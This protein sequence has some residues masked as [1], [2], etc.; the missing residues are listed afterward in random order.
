MRWIKE[1][2][3]A[4]SLDEL[5]SSS[6]IRG[7]SMP[8][9]EG[10][11]EDVSRDRFTTWVKADPNTTLERHVVEVRR[12]LAE[13]RE[14]SPRMHDTP[15]QECFFDS[16]KPNRSSVRKRLSSYIWNPGPR[17]GKDGA[18]EKQISGKWHDITLQEAIMSTT[19]SLRTGST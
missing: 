8:N 2:E 5:R 11:K 10:Y 3:M 12:A 19:I 1:V 7:I 4:D 6:S 9:F 13:H 15:G 18:I 14:A 17:R 16:R